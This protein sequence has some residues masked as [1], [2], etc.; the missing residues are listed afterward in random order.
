MALKSSTL[1]PVM[2]FSPQEQVMGTVAVDI[3]DVH[4]DRFGVAGFNLG[5]RLVYDRG[6][7]HEAGPAAWDED[8]G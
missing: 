7:V 5:R 1:Q 2:T 4:I 3:A 8:L 6:D